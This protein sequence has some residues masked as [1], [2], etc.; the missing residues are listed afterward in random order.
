MEKYVEHGP[1]RGSDSII[2][3]MKYGDTNDNCPLCI[4]IKDILE[5]YVPGVGPSEIRSGQANEKQSG[6]T[7]SRTE[8]DTA[9]LMC[10]S[11]KGLPSN[12]GMVYLAIYTV[13]SMFNARLFLLEKPTKN[14]TCEDPEITEEPAVASLDLSDAKAWLERCR[15][16]QEEA[17]A[18]TDC[19]PIQTRPRVPL[20][21]IDCLNRTVR[22]S[23]VGEPY[24]CLSYVWGKC[25]VSSAFDGSALPEDLPKTIED[26]ISVSIA[27]GIPQLWVDQYCINQTNVEDKMKTIQD[28]NL[29]YG[30]AEL[31]I[32]AASGQDASAGLPGVQE[33]PRNIRRL[34]RS[35]SSSFWMSKDI[36]MSFNKSVWN[37]RG[38]TF[39]EGLLSKRRL[40]FTDARLYGQCSADADAYYL[41]PFHPSITDYFESSQEGST[42]RLFPPG[43]IL[44]Q[45]HFLL[46]RLRAYF[47]RRLSYG[48]DSLNAFQGVLNAFGGNKHLCGIPFVQKENSPSRQGLLT[49]LDNLG[50]MI[51]HESSQERTIPEQTTSTTFPSWTWAA[52]KELHPSNTDRLGVSD[53]EGYALGYDGLD[54]R[55]PRRR[56]AGP[57]SD[58][59][60]RT[61]EV[62]NSQIASMSLKE[63]ASSQNDGDT[64]P[65]D[66]S[67]IDLTSWSVA[68]QMRS[69]PSGQL[70]FFESSSLEESVYLDKV[71]TCR[72]G[73][74][75]RLVYLCTRIRSRTQVAK[76]TMLLFKKKRDL[77][78]IRVVFM[79]VREAEPAK[80]QRIGLLHVDPRDPMSQEWSN[81]TDPEE[82]FKTIFHPSENADSWSWNRGVLRLI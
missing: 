36:V 31:T 49:F 15:S 38:W 59:Q 64:E 79:L 24:I 81:L 32:I 70:V 67:Y 21:V 42:I 33:T 51:F 73:D 40:V 75:I 37:T 71:D 11:E 18:H 57:S 41:E 7:A 30:G 52:Y 61:Q 19:A 58:P 34:I 72:A 13:G 27:F 12:A 2:A 26:A 43:P 68:A 69:S 55:I 39:Q 46:D 65:N 48:S 78:F 54:V 22:Q 63:F 14:L 50:W 82:I 66:I 10:Y 74:S 6:S 35:S 8:T 80:Y 1:P 20:R 76:R 29:I 53:S 77:R 25:S 28:M 17:D 3:V 56:P 9:H 47:V 62:L 60:I 45:R 5:E 44:E 4:L 23:H 16:G